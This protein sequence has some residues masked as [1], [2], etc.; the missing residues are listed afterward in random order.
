MRKVYTIISKT[1]FS[2]YAQEGVK[3]F[4]S[5]KEAST[6]LEETEKFSW[7]DFIG[8]QRLVAESADSKA[9]NMLKKKEKAKN[10]TTTPTNTP[11]KTTK[12][13]TKKSK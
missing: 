9:A 3:T 7:K 11:A 4:R 13:T 2:D 8:Y 10:K 12:P 1:W 6:F 5:Y